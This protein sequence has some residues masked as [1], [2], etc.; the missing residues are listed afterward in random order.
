ML[1]G[2]QECLPADILNFLNVFQ[3]LVGALVD[4]VAGVERGVWLEE[5]EPAFFVGDW[6]VND[7][8]RD[9]DKLAF[10]DGFEMFAAIFFAVVHLESAFNDEE[11]FVF[12]LVM[13][14]DELAFDLV[15]F[16]GLSVEFGGDVGLPEFGDVRELFGDVDFGH[17]GAGVGLQASGKALGDVCS[18]QFRVL[19]VLI[20]PAEK[21]HMRNLLRV[22]IA[23]SILIGGLCVGSA[24]AQQK[25]SAK[26]AAKKSATPAAAEK[27]TEPANKAEA[28]AE[29][30]PA[31]SGDKDKDEKEEHFDMT[32]VA[33]VVTHHQ[34]TVDGKVLKYAATAGRLPIKR[35]DGKIE[36]EMFYVAYTLDGEAVDKRPLTFAFNG[37]PGSASI[38]LHMGALGPRKVVLQP[39]GF[40]PPAPYKIEDNPYTLLDKSDLVLIDAIGTGFSRAADKEMMKKF[41]GVNGDIEAFSEFIRLYITRNERWPSPLFILGE[42]YGTTRAAGIS[43]Y[44]A[45]RG[46]SFNGI[47]LLSTVL[48]FQTL[49]DNPSNDQPYIF[50]LPSYTMIA[51][52]HHKLA[53]DL[54]ADM[55]KARSEA[56]KWAATDYARALDKGDSMTAAERQAV[57]DQMARYT[58]LSKEVID[59]ANLR[60]NVPKFT[61]YLLIDQKLRTGRLDGRYTG[62][63]PQGLL[64]TNFYDPTGSATLPPYTSVF[65]NYL[66][67][68]LEYKTDMPY[69]VRATERGPWEWGNAIQGYPDTAS[70]MREAIVKNPYLKIFVMEG[71]YDLATPYFAV[72]YTVDHLNLPQKYRDNISYA[73]YE[74]GHMVY[75]P[76]DGLK[77]MKADQAAFMQKAQ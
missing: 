61:H 41:W 11:E 56:E 58:G 76:M 38:W 27:P 12:V 4:H 36:A 72:N 19:K 60:I 5:E 30:K 32:E 62:P 21:Q 70:A 66:R 35:G 9:D 69:N 6:L 15:E 17:G 20:F 74:S 44:L 53:P 55:N 50:L 39:D 77:K 29:V 26:P 75:L 64:D 14:E 68:E 65:N 3:G 8:A 45:D 33:P 10:F 1:A 49:L 2:G 67:T 37:G 23:I 34:I 63:D 31:A 7:A 48:N 13:M 51:G 40:M 59:E 57:I 18:V 47:T 16:H 46:I 25:E 52:Y 22:V 54:A 42:S 43:G 28:A 73:T 24:S 71:Y